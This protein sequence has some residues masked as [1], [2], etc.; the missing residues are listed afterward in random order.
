MNNGNIP[1]ELSV[2]ANEFGPI[3]AITVT[4]EY[5]DP[6]AIRA[7][8]NMWGALISLDC[9]QSSQASIISFHDQN[10]PVVPYKGGIP[11]EKKIT[12]WIQ[13]RMNLPQY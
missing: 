4:P 6:F 12:K 8:G 11:Y 3:D 2:V 1:P 7:V 13:A 9:L 10:D 5:N